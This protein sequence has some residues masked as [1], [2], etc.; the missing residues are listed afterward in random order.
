MKMWKLIGHPTELDVEFPG[1]FF[2]LR[3]PKIEHGI[4]C[5]EEGSCAGFDLH[6]VSLQ[7]HEG[8]KAGSSFKRLFDQIGR[9]EKDGFG[10]FFSSGVEKDA[11]YLR[12]GDLDAGL[13][14]NLKACL[15]NL[16]NVEC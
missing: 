1:E 11:T 16:F 13:G 8:D 4:S 10:F 5:P 7:V 12:V 6:P 14:E 9:Q 3:S 15:M 2:P